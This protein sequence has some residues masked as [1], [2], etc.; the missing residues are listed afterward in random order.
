MAQPPL[1][2]GMDASPTKT[3]TKCKE[4]KPLDEFYEDRRKDGR[5][6]PQCKECTKARGKKYRQ[7][8]FE[9]VKAFKKKY[10][11]EN[12][13]EIAE[14]S[15]QWREDNPDRVKAQYRY[16]SEKSKKW[17]QNNPD[18]ISKRNKRYRQNNPG[19]T[20]AHTAKR[21]A[22]K[23]KRTPPWAD[24]KAIEAV[25]EEARALQESTGTPYHVDHIYPLQGET[26]SGLHVDYNLRAVPAKVNMSK[27]NRFG[28]DDH[29]EI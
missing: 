17:S 25:Y 7:D 19:K 26:V 6:S 27:G 29:R 14:K 8:N 28:P 20:N 15:K 2:I 11:R 9:I 23:L 24:M 12:S 21:R 1:E 5:H 18:K 4:E 16:N 3:C 22:A 10:S 13:V